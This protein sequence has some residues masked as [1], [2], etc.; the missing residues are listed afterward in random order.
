MKTITV[1]TDGSEGAGRAVRFASELA[2]LA[3]AKLHIVTVGEE[4]SPEMRKF[5][6]SEG[7]SPGDIFENTNQATLADA[8]QMAATAGLTGIVLHSTAGDAAESILA[9]VGKMKPDLLVVGRRG[10]GRLRGLVFGSVSQK[11]SALAPCPVLV[12]N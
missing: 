1:A 5:A 8:R 11:L 3:Q 10:R 4:M 9:V 12:V 7:T 2:V 6:D